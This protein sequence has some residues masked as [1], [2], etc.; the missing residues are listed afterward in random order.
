MVLNACASEWGNP[1]TDAQA[2]KTIRAYAPYENVR[3][4]DYPNLFVTAGL[5]DPRVTYWSRRNGWRGCAR[6]RPTTT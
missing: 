1:K 5:N 6:V 2:F 3:A 4:Q